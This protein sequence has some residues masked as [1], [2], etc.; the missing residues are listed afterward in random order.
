MRRRDFR[1]PWAAE[2]K[3]AKVDVIVTYGYPAALAAD[4][5]IE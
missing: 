4:E 1:G 3:T 2:L 5:G